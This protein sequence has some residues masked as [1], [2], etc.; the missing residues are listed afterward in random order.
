M[1]KE[2]KLNYDVEKLLKIKEELNKVSDELTIELTKFE[3][4]INKLNIGVIAFVPISP[5]IK[6]GYTKLDKKWG[7]VCVY[8]EI[9]KDLEEQEVTRR[10]V[11]SPRSVRFYTY[12]HRY[13][14]LP[15]IEKVAE[16]LA[17]RI[18]KTLDG[19]E[20][21]ESNGHE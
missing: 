19:I 5:K 6:I 21:P 3:D 17:R 2:I 13:L 20:E 12:K 15:A 14:L 11:D 4:D 18:R 1:E 8:P 10:W 9:T 7:I 16:S